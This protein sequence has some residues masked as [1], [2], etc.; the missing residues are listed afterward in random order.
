MKKIILK[1]INRNLK[2]DDEGYVHVNGILGIDL[3][4]Y[5]FTRQISRHINHLFDGEYDEIVNDWAEKY[6]HQYYYRDSDYHEWTKKNAYHR[7]KGPARAWEDGSK[8]WYVNGKLH[9][10]NDLPACI[11]P[12]KK[13]EWYRNDKLHRDYDLPAVI[14][15]DGRKEWYN[16]GVKINK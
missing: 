2:V 11:Y 15:K 3:T 7:E 13:K 16:N 14:C 12:N 8:E 9:R 6:D 1:Y 4:D 10:D 5:D